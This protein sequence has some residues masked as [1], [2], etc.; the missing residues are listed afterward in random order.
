[1]DAANRAG[2]PL[3]SPIFVGEFPTYEMNGCVIPLP[4]GK[5]ILV[6]S[7]LAFLLQ[8][9]S[10]AIAAFRVSNQVAGG[11]TWPTVGFD[12]QGTEITTGRL[13]NVI[14]PYV[15]LGFRIRPEG[16]VVPGLFQYLVS[17]LVFQGALD[18][19]VAHEVGH[20]V[21]GHLS[22]KQSSWDQEFEADETGL[23]LACDT[24]DL[25]AATPWLAELI[26]ETRFAGA[27]LFLRLSA[28]LDDVVER[29]AVR[30]L[31]HIV[32]TSRP[33]KPDMTEV[34][35]RA[36]LAGAAFTHPP[37]I[38]RYDRIRSM[39]PHNSLKVVNVYSSSIED[40]APAVIANIENWAM[41]ALQARGTT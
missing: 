38:K 6:N 9:V 33:P 24:Q 20:V 19:V 41:R 14:I 13:A 37:A 35:D 11:G 1:M 29:S 10:Q 23:K 4:G 8:H 7:G 27:I 25:Q 36:R 39:V 5:L 21:K 34:Y 28:L 16:P 3:T 17:A 18:F 31:L 40:L 30:S 2:V 32:E 22:A 26:R 12:K 15:F